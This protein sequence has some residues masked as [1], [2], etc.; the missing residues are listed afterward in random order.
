M[1][2]Q[3]IVPLRSASDRI[4][5][6]IRRHELFKCHCLDSLGCENTDSLS[7]TA[8]F[9]GALLFLL[10]R[11]FSKLSVYQNHLEGLLKTDCW[12]PPGF[13][14]QPVWGRTRGFAFL[15]SSQVM[16]MLRV[17]RPHFAKHCLRGLSASKLLE[18]LL[19]MHLL[20][21]SHCQVQCV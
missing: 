17:W 4:R 1:Q 18:T 2:R 5:T 7:H 19:E 13:L 15:I 8:N 16:L 10:M 20:G 11:W 9:R 3:V 12:G 21:F 14:I 6:Q